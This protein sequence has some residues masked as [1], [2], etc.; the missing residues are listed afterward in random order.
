MVVESSETPSGRSVEPSQLVGGRLADRYRLVRLVSQGANSAIFDAGDEQTGRTVTLKVVRPRLAAAPTFRQRFDEQM[1][2]VAALTH[3]NI[4]A[5]YDWGM[6]RL[7]PASTAYVVIEHLTGGSLRDM[8]DRRRRL[9]PS[10]ALVVGLDACRGLDHAHRR[11]FVHTEL[12]PSKLVFGDDRRMRIVDF[13]LARLLGE[14]GWAQPD[15]VSTHVAWY[16]SPEQALSL[17]VDGKS[18]VYALCLT[19]HEAV[20]G[21][22]PF[23]SDSTVASLSARVGRLMPVSADLGP[24]AAVFER[25]GRPEA[26]ER[27]SAAEF[28]KGLVK[29]ASKLPRPEPLPLLSTGLFET[30][31]EQ[32]RSPEDPT[33]GVR[34]PGAATTA[35]IVVVPLDESGPSA[36]DDESDVSGDALPD[37][38]AAAAA[39]AAAA[40]S[41]DLDAPAGR[42]EVDGDDGSD[43]DVDEGDRSD[44]D[45]ADHDEA[46]AGATDDGRSGPSDN[47]AFVDDSADG[48][49]DQHEGPEIVEAEPDADLSV[50]RPDDGLVILPLDTGIP[51]EATPTESGGSRSGEADAAGAPAGAGVAT[52]L[53]DDRRAA[54]DD[55]DR[56]TDDDE[57]IATFSSERDTETVP[58]V[59]DDTGDPDDPDERSPRRFPWKILI[60]FLVIASLVA[61][62]ILAARLFRTPTYEVPVLQ[63][64]PEAEARNLIGGNN[65]DLTVDIERSDEVPIVGRVVRTV[66]SAGGQV[67]EGEPFLMVVSGGPTLREL[68]D[69]VGVPLSEVQ[70]TLL[71]RGLDVETEVAFDEDVPDGS[72]VSWSVPDEPGLVAGDMVEPE[73][74]V[75]LVVSEGPAPRTVPSLAGLTVGEARRQIEA[76]QLE[77]VEGQ[78]VFSDDVVL[79]SVVSQ[80]LTV[81]S[82]VERGSTVTVVVSIGP[83]LVL[84]PDI[85]ATP[86]FAEA[87]TVLRDAGFAPVLALGDNLGRVQRVTIDG[88]EPAV[89]ETFRRG[90]QVDIVAI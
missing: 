14:Q 10:Q 76:L 29:V 52:A 24:L 51:D 2:G 82:E 16:A 89:G 80:D 71:E 57:P 25:A 12:T 58:I 50:D 17:P 84:Y 46:D 19:L 53:L 70:T 88:R 59:G 55:T 1:R 54:D 49:D 15:S 48:G 36:G 56:D 79:G 64:L 90:T 81:G 87:A 27:S 65:W 23:R 20:T 33:G 73:T 47:D 62:G 18:D 4:A 30:P 7:G 38:S 69:S 39:T 6:A 42:S 44:A 83:D 75:R 32:L 66:P 74:V 61:L 45:R 26:D 3:P 11:G 22:L 85:S 5:V 37:G 28:G 41:L 31:V 21:S 86:V 68:P 9:S 43:A 13:G 35:E 78:Q 77:F 67:A 8:F 40:T 72:V 34:R 63:E 60:G